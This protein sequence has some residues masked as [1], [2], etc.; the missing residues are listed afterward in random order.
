MTRVHSKADYDE[1]GGEEN[2][3]LKADILL[4]PASP[5]FFPTQPLSTSPSVVA[6]FFVCIRIPTQTQEYVQGFICLFILSKYPFMFK[7]SVHLNHH[8]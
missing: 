4:T 5:T 6:F 3:T 2:R 1:M 7:K 8:L